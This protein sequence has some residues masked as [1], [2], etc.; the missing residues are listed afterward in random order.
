MSS[1]FIT[2]NDQLKGALLETAIDSGFRLAVKNNKLYIV[3]MLT[4]DLGG[5][6]L[7]IPVKFAG[8]GFE[9]LDVVQVPE[10]SI[11]PAFRTMYEVVHGEPPEPVMIKGTPMDTKEDF[12]NQ[13]EAKQLDEHREALG[14]WN[15]DRWHRTV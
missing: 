5:F 14:N 13:P 15:A 12:P 8:E 1:N 6:P 9:D 3:D 2:R 4:N 7:A 11:D 10:D